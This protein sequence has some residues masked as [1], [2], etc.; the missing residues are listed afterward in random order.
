MPT[1]DVAMARNGSREMLAGLGRRDIATTANNVKT[2]FSSWSNCMKA[3][4]CK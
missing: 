3:T 4:Y 1:I 2:S